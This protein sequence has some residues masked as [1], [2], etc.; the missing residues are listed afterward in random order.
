M[1]YPAELQALPQARTGTLP[2][3]ESLCL[4]RVWRGKNVLLGEE[5]IGEQELFSPALQFL[6]KRHQLLRLLSCQPVFF[7]SKRRGQAND[8]DGCLHLA[9]AFD[10]S[11]LVRGDAHRTTGERAKGIDCAASVRT[12]CGAGQVLELVAYLFSEMVGPIVQQW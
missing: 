9:G 8:R 6:A 1:L 4:G 7:F 3:G 10:A 2:Q 5:R 12:E 11:V